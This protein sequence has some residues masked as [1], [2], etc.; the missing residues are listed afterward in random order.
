M[1][2]ARLRELTERLMRVR[3]QVAAERDKVQNIVN[4]ATGIAIIGT[5]EAGRVTLFNPGAQRLLGYARDEALGL[6]SERAVAVDEQIA[7]L[8]RVPTHDG[9]L[10]TGLF[11]VDLTG[12]RL[13]AIPMRPERVLTG[14]QQAG[15][16]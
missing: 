5:D 4:A 7:S 9:A 14:L 1:P 16:Q 6:L 15:G 12:V 13:T 2:P 8:E 3:S 10:G 11:G